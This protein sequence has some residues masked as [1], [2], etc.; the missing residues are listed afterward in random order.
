[1]LCYLVLSFYSE[2]NDNFMQSRGF[3][4][5]WHTETCKHLH[6][7]VD[8]LNDKEMFSYYFG[9]FVCGTVYILI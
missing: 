2:S 8:V 3:S 5:L 6:D 7:I 4:S 9:I 1:M